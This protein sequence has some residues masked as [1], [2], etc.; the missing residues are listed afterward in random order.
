MGNPLKALGN[1]WHIWNIFG[2]TFEPETLETWSRAL[3]TRILAK[4]PKILW[5]TILARGIGWWRHII[6]QK[7]DPHPEPIGPKPPSKLK[8]FFFILNYTKPLVVTGFEQLSSSICCRGMAG[9]NSAWKGKV[10]FFWKLTFLDLLKHRC[11]SEGTAKFFIV[12]L[13]E[14]RWKN[15]T[16]R[17]NAFFILVGTIVVMCETKVTAY[18]IYVYFY[19]TYQLPCQDWVV[20]F[21]ANSCLRMTHFVNRNKSPWNNQW[22]LCEV[23]L[24]FWVAA[25]CTWRKITMKDL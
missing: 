5:A 6:N 14:T 9:Q 25:S 16:A 22:K 1:S 7:T 4:N 23:C 24:H 8:T 12:G 13:L 2:I 10:C 19:K 11:G 15:A 3:K 20:L 17:P 18:S 21:S